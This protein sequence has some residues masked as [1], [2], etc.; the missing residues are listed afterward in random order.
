MLLLLRRRRRRRRRLIALII[1]QARASSVA[2]PVAIKAE[3]RY[4]IEQAVI[5]G[6]RLR[7]LLC[8]LL[9][10]RMLYLLHLNLLALVQRCIILDDMRLLLL[11]SDV[12]NATSSH[13]VAPSNTAYHMTPSL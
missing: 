11:S 13:T 8:L 3:R 7:L 10:L 2:C 12:P 5:Y 1:R 9:Y 4:C 6:L